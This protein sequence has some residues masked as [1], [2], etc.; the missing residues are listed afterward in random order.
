MKGY[1][2]DRLSAPEM[3]PVPLKPRGRGAELRLLHC[4]EVL[5]K[6]LREAGEN[7]LLA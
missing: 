1:G 7:L 2:G 3:P 6:G 4:E 5:R